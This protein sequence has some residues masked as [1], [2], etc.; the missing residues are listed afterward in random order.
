MIPVP[1]DRSE[2]VPTG[3]VKSTVLSEKSSYSSTLRQ[4]NRVL[5]RWASLLSKVWKCFFSVSERGKGLCFLLCFPH[6]LDKGI[7]DRIAHS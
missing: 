2:D 4:L 7:S 1:H 5:C 6:F 3:T